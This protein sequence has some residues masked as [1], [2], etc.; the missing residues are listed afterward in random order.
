[1]LQM[2]SVSKVTTF[3]FEL[4]G[5]VSTVLGIFCKRINV[6]HLYRGSIC[7][8]LQLTNDAILSLVHYRFITVEVEENF[9]RQEKTCSPDRENR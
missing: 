3:H 6:L 4:N 9:I 8:L 5:I 7:I 1:M 2:K